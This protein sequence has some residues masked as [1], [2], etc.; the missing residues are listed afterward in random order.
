MDKEQ[1]DRVTEKERETIGL[2]TYIAYVDQEYLK[3]LTM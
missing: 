1:E 3:R 2:L